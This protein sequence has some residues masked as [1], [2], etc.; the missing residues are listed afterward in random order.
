MKASMGLVCVLTLMWAA[1]AVAA[2]RDRVSQGDL[3]INAGER[4]GDAVSFGGSVTVRGEVTGD[5]V[6]FAGDVRLMPGA[7]VE[8]DITAFG[9]TIIVEPGAAALGEQTSFG[10]RAGAE[11]RETPG[12]GTA[13][14]EQR[15]APPLAIW[16][17]HVQDRI[18]SFFRHVGHMIGL[19][20]LLV[21]L[22]AVMLGAAPLR[23]RALAAAVAAHPGKSLGLGL[24]VILASVVLMILL[25]VTIIGIPVAA[26]LTVALGIGALLGLTGVSILIGEL[27]PFP[28]LRDR[29]FVKLMAGAGILV[30]ALSI[31]YAG[32]VIG[33]IATIVGIGSL[34]FTRMRPGHVIFG[35]GKGPYRTPAAL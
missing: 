15:S 10:R 9:G 23:T 31:P 16:L 25:S 3:V 8:G 14:A 18:R 34:A 20:V 1:T 17:A 33:V 6:A 30:L 4:V 2:P 26:V 35:G 22:G 7:R 21:I 11:G 12:A 24:L 29:Q 19:Y 27:L 28:S 13:S 5:A 32:G